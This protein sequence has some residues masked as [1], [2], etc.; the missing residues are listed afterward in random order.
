MRNPLISATKIMIY[1]D[2]TNIF[3]KKVKKWMQKK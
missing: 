3:D 1:S 2:T